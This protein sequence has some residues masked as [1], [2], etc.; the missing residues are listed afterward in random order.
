MKTV[1]YTKHPNC[2]ENRYN[3][4][5]A[6]A[7]RIEEELHA[8]NVTVFYDSQEDYM[9]TE[10]D[11]DGDHYKLRTYKILAL[12]KNRI[13]GLFEDRRFDNDDEL[14]QFFEAGKHKTWVFYPEGYKPLN[15]DV[16]EDSIVSVMWGEYPKDYEFGMAKFSDGVWR[17]YGQPDHCA[18]GHKC[19]TP[20]AWHPQTI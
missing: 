15:A 18:N 3:R 2:D 8:Q 1:P 4:S 14:L 17:A 19:K 10:W 9:V 12:T 7:Q 5:I 13:S 16:P 20:S 6:R 11:L